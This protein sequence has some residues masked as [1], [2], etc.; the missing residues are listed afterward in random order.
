MTLNA[1]TSYWRVF[2]PA[3]HMDNKFNPATHMDNNNGCNV[4]LF[5]DFDPSFGQVYL[6]EMDLLNDSELGNYI[7]GM[8]KDW[9]DIVVGQRIGTHA[10]LAVIDTVH[11]HGKK[12][13]TE[14]D[15]NVFEVPADHPAFKSFYPGGIQQQITKE[16]LEISDG[17]IVSNHTNDLTKIYM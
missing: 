1:G 7:G 4:T 15:D 9:A 10:G 14:I 16:Q 12:F 17:L 8:L 13:F 5:P 6:W 11:H 2:N 3:T